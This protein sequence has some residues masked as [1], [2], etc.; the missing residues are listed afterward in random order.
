MIKNT[1]L[2]VIGAGI[3]GVASA[4]YAKRAGLELILFESAIVGGQL[5]FMEAVDNYVGT[6]FGIK[7]R[8]LA[9]RLTKTLNDLGIE[10]IKEEI[11]KAKISG[12]NVKL[13]S[14]DSTYNSGG[15]I[16]A[17]GASFKK[18][19]INGE[20]DFL[21]RGISYCAICDGFFFKDKDVAV[22]GGG[23]TAVEEAIYLSNI[24]RKVTL[25]HRRNKLRAMDYLVAELSRRGNVE[26]VLNSTVK[27]IKGKDF[28]GEVVIEN[29]NDNKSYSLQ[30]NG[31][32]IAIGI[33]PNTEVFKDIVETDE[34]GFILTNEE[35]KSS[36]DFIWAAGDCRRRPLRQLLTA[37]AE[38]S[39]AAISA[40][41]YL[42]G[43]YISS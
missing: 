36:C 43:Q 6:E 34:G 11:V 27:E 39:V 23:N 14:K 2:T 41:K 10:T 20:E 21:G 37:A 26:I 33:K 7:G 1:E 3:A 17:T 8:E 35:M 4:V 24:C 5:L 32:F 12:K 9:Q 22:V 31:L 29:I 38:G 16:I 28:L 13:H 40:Y 25:I 19:G 30:L 42:K 18:L 15:L